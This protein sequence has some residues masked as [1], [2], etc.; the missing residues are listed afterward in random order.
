MTDKRDFKAVLDEKGVKY[1]VKNG[2]VNIGGS[3]Y[4]RGYEHQFKADALT[5]IGGSLDLEGYEHDFN[6]GKI[7]IGEV[8]YIG[9]LCKYDFDIIDGIGCV[10]LSQKEKDGIS[11]RRCQRSEFKDGKIIGKKFYVASKDGQD[12][13]AKTIKAAIDDLAFKTGD[14]DVSEFEN[15]PLKTVK[16][17][18]E[19][20][21][22]YRQC[23]GACH[24]GIEMFMGSKKL[25]NTYSLKEIL[26]ETK[27]QYGH[28]VFEKVIKDE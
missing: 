26:R 19:W 5:S 4:L 18:K 10:V 25:K 9:K 15:M 14:R 22:I 24:L 3:L 13:H 8:L 11:I 17:P 16:T 27:G 2:K 20:A 12:A 1:L 21:F 6:F 28:D 7:D 23:T